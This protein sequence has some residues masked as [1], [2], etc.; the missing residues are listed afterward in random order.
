MTLRVL[1]DIG[2][3]AHVHL[4]KHVIW[5]IQ[6][7]GGETCITTRQKDV[8]TNLLDAYGLEYHVIGKY[9]NQ[10]DRGMSFIFTNYKLLKIARKFNPH[11]FI[12]VAS[13]HAAQVACLTGRQCIILEDTENKSLQYALYVPLVSKV[14]TPKTFGKN[15]GKKHVF[16]DGYH[17][18]A[19]LLPQYFKP[20]PEILTKYGLS[21]NDTFSVVRTVAWKATHDRGQQGITD[22]DSIIDYLMKYGKIV[23]SSET[24]A[25]SS[26][27]KYAI[28]IAPEDMHTILAYA[29]LYVGEGA[30]MTSESVAL[31]T[32]AIY[33]N[34]QR[35][36]VLDAQI[37][38]GLLYQV[39]PTQ[40]TERE[41][42]RIIDNIMSSSKET[43]S[44]KS[45]QFLDNKID[46]IDFIIKEI[47][48]LALQRF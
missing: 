20:N 29:R 44:E 8:A 14:L 35:A 6:A 25:K 16:Y 41:I 21:I 2:H 30:T 43:Y 45:R 24:D 1:V 18:M 7:L 34:S 39:S 33:V 11:V 37:K 31:G 23:I 17:E 22:I 38:A 9:S 32:P 19:Y 12:G 10:L 40:N 36:G 28:K 48:N 5:G 47:I 26:L 13:I 42:I 3:P 4:F 46:V 27:N 15:M